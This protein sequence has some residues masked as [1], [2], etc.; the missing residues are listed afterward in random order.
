LS[1]LGEL[2]GGAKNENAMLEL[3]HIG[4]TNPI[5]SLVSLSSSLSK[6]S[7]SGVK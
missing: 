2:S 1:K 4:K 3:A 5:L 7:L 6:D